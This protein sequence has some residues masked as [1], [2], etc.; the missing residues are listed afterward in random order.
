MTERHPNV[1]EVLICEI[2]QDGKADVVLGK[3]LCVLS[4]AELRQPVSDLLH[5]G[6]ALNPRR[7]LYTF[8]ESL[9]DRRPAA[10]REPTHAPEPGGRLPGGPPRQ[11]RPSS[12]R[13]RNPA[14]RLTSPPRRSSVNILWAT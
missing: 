7:Q 13:R 6:S 9:P 14:P 5:R 4:E 12:L 10:R 1:L 2:R 3:A 11:K 8:P